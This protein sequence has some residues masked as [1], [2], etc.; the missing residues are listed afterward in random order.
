VLRNLFWQFGDKA[1]RIV[2]YSTAQ[3]TFN[4]VYDTTHC[5]IINIL[6]EAVL[7]LLRLFLV[8]QLFIICGE[9]QCLS[10]THVLKQKIINNNYY[11]CPHI[12]K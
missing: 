6:W 1:D 2:A 12:Q 10:C 9:M 4:T 8:R 3:Y 11:L 5:K 7:R